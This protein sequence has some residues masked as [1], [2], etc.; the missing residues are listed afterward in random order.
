M[1]RSGSAS[2]PVVAAVGPGPERGMGHPCWG[3]RQ[4]HYAESKWH[5]RCEKGCTGETL[6]KKGRLGGRRKNQRSGPTGWWKTVP[7]KWENLGKG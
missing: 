7:Q 6:C 4:K 2:S 1:Q 5:P 3:M